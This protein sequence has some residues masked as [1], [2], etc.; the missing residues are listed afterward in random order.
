MVSKAL[1][2]VCAFANTDGGFLALGIE[3]FDK[4]QGSN[5]LFGVSE[6]PEA[7]DELERKLRSHLTPPLGGVRWQRIPFQ[8]P[9]GQ[10][11]KIV[12]LT[13]DKSAKAHSILD[14][15][16]YLRLETS[17]RQM[18]AVE[19]V[20]L[21]FTRGERSIES[22][23]VDV[24][25]DLLDT[26]AWK[27]YSKARGFQ[28]Q[29]TVVERMRAIGLALEVEGKLRPLIAAVLLFADD[30]SGLLAAH[31]QSRAGIRVFHYSGSEIQHTAN[32]NLIKTPKTISGPLME[33]ISMAH[34]YVLNELASGLV[35]PGS[36]FKTAH[37]YP[38]RVIKEA[39]TNAVIHRDYRMNKDIHIR[40]FDD[41]MEVESPGLFPGNLTAQTIFEAGSVARNSVIANH[42][43]EFP[44]PPNVDAG[45]GVKM[46]LSEMR[47]N[48]LFPPLYA[49]NNA[50]AVPSITLMLLNENLP[51]LW[52]QVSDWVTREGAIS[53]RK[54]TEIAGVDTLRASKMLKRWVERGLLVKDETLG[55]AKTV[56]RKAALQQNELPGFDSKP[57]T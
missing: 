57:A 18:S 56:Y 54:L 19:I 12:L 15:G 27:A 1:E 37:A 44:D 41:R 33:Q 55:R 23:T 3:D 29:A 22:Y 11:D 34:R 5:R 7:V 8:H 50:L 49:E 30:P 42:L 48:S 17:N 36:G 6:N 16:T 40:I 9:D 43:R 39:I 46:M 52:D 25:F 28:T 31:R 35:I 13:V 4:A 14:G 26:A 2:T 45:E 32:P 21:S 51:P 47:A 38:E 53:N 24:S 10:T 20:D